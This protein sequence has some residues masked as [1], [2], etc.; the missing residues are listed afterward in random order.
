MQQ[1]AQLINFWKEKLKLTDLE[2]TAFEEIDRED[3]V[4][5]K[6]KNASNKRITLASSPSQF[7][8]IAA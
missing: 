2:L 7:L 8:L 6:F 5:E 3:F 4:L 1:K